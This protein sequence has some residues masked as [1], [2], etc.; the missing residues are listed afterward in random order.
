MVSPTPVPVSQE[1][2]VPADPQAD[3]DQQQPSVQP[4]IFNATHKFQPG[5]QATIPH[6]QPH[7]ASKNANDSDSSVR[8]GSNSPKKK[9][10]RRYSN[11]DPASSAAKSDTKKPNPVQT[12]SVAP[13]DSAKS[14]SKPRETHTHG[15]YRLHSNQPTKLPQR[16]KSPPMYPYSTSEDQYENTDEDEIS[17]E[18][19]ILSDTSSIAGARKTPTHHKS[20]LPVRSF[21]RKSFTSPVPSKKGDSTTTSSLSASGKSSPTPPPQTSRAPPPPPTT[22]ASQPGHSRNAS[23]SVSNASQDSTDTV[24]L[25]VVTPKQSTE[26]IDN[27]RAKPASHVSPTEITMP[28]EEESAKASPLSPV[29]APEQV[30]KVEVIEVKPAS[31]TDPSTVVTVKEKERRQ[32]SNTSSNSNSNSMTVETETVSA[33]PTLAVGAATSHLKV[34]KSI[35]NVNK[36][37]QRAKK[38][39]SNRGHG[40]SKAEVFAARIASAV[41]EVQSSD[42][43]E[44]FVYESNPHENSTLMSSQSSNSMR[45][46]FQTRNPSSSSLQTP[47]LHQASSQSLVSPLTTENAPT[48]TS[49]GPDSYQTLTQTRRFNAQKQYQ[50][51][52]LIQQQQQLL[53]TEEQKLSLHAPA[54]P[55]QPLSAK[56]SMQQIN[57]TGQPTQP[58]LSHQNSFYGTQKHH[59]LS[60]QSSDNLSTAGTSNANQSVLMQTT[61]SAPS[62][63]GDMGKTLKK[64]P[65]NLRPTTVS[66]AGSGIPSPRSKRGASVNTAPKGGLKKQVSSQLRNLPSKH[67]ETLNGGYKSTGQHRRRMRNPGYDD[68]EEE[69]DYN[70]IDDDFDDD[71]EEEYFEYNEATPLRQA[72]SGGS[73]NAP[74][75]LRKAGTTSLR[76]YS[77]HNYQ[78][79]REAMTQYQRVRTALWLILAVLFILATGFSMGFLLAT[80]QPLRGVVIADIFDV[81]VS[82]EEL[83]FDVVVDGI[84]PGFMSIE[85]NDVDIDIFARSQYVKEEFLHDQFSMDKSDSSGQFT[86]LLGNIQ[87]FEVPL[88]FEGGVFSKRTR[89]SVGQLR[90]VHPGRNTTAPHGGDDDDDD[91][92]DD[93]NNGGS[94]SGHGGTGHGDFDGDDDFGIFIDHIRQQAAEASPPAKGPKDGTDAGQKRWARVSLKPF[95]LIVRGVLRY[96]LLLN[97]NT[98]VNSVSKTVHVDPSK[99]SKRVMEVVSSSESD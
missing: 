70:D 78:R 92:D 40:S 68:E 55:K 20:S 10:F 86:M 77:P 88:T 91:D 81:L 53:A 12:S 80:T 74:R 39:K 98:K 23:G 26:S 62:V 75:R 27:K 69:Y 59:A 97:P 58:L 30:E 9:K 6:P 84:N 28:S 2:S 66:G 1:N 54:G 7:D 82:D 17:G 22:N 18:E 89:R 8:S 65:S 79:K 44:T 48:I 60:S 96:D 46:R 36:S 67:F 72:G 71:D 52:L 11:V 50:Q 47:N 29:I 3:R 41:D 33:V 5:Q 85:V 43:D 35:D 25:P 93:N 45:P 73:V 42:S 49:N 61:E 94:G 37:Q 31:N 63:M 57:Q 83:I 32:I 21:R 90:L 64:K 51:Q 34:K 95:D 87:K 4:P 14:H 56:S 38:K 19:N 24:T 99:S 15:S 13:A 16:V 76:S